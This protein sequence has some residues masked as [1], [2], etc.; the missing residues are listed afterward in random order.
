M[1]ELQS[2]LRQQI[3]EG[4][5]EQIRTMPSPLREVFVLRHYEGRTEPQ[6]ADLM[7][8]QQSQVV[9]L[10]RQAER[11][12]YHRVRDLRPPLDDSFYLE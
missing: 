6:I 3:F 4:I 12:L 7:G 11:L 1:I 9:H 5:V 8:I 2:D 10:L